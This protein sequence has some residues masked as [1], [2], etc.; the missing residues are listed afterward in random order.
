[1]S[2]RNSTVTIYLVLQ[3]CLLLFHKRVYIEFMEIELCGLPLPS[4][5]FQLKNG[6]R[7]V[8]RLDFCFGGACVVSIRKYAFE[9]YTYTNYV[10]RT[11]V[12]NRSSTETSINFERVQQSKGAQST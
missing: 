5:M 9:I 3:I 12:G 10:L 7:F 4:D 6:F 11:T 1:M 8:F 2:I